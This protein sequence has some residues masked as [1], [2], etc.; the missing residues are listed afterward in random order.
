MQNDDA[1]AVGVD[2]GTDS[3]RA[4]LVRTCDGAV[5]ASCSHPY[6]RW[7]KGLYSE[8]ARMRFRQHPHDYAEALRAVL[9]GVLDGRNDRDR[10]ACIGVDATASTPCLTDA[11]G[12]PLSLQPAF[13]AEPDAMFVLWKDHTAESEAR[14]ITEAARPHGYCLTTV[15]SIRRKTAGR[16]CGTSS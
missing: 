5:L 3:A 15:G 1:L 4:L 6:A 2:F 11:E 10:I 8:A 9:H 16:R 13:A 14:Q 12:L 7:G